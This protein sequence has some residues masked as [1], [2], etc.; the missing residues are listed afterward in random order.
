MSREESNKA[1]DDGWEDG[2]YVVLLAVDQEYVYF[3]DP[4][5][6]MSKG[7]LPRSRRIGMVLAGER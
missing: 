3:E 1:V 2:H 4:Y 7:F 6:R 5:V